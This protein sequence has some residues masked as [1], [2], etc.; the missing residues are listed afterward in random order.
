MFWKPFNR[1]H[2]GYRMSS[3]AKREYRFQSFRPDDPTSLA[4]RLYADHVCTLT[5][6]EEA[7]EM[8][9]HMAKEMHEDGVKGRNT[10]TGLGLA[11]G[12]M[13][14][15]DLETLEEKEFGKSIR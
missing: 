5:S 12:W 3:E 7:L 6:N 9:R 4:F 14:S 2:V 15:I 8:L 1:N 11:T 10:V 13:A